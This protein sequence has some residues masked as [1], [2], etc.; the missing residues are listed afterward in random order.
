V[1]APGV[2]IYS[3]YLPTL[4]S[5]RSAS[6]TSTA[7]PHVSGLAGLLASK[8]YSNSEV[9]KRIESTAFDLGATGKDPEFGW[10]LI[11]AEAA[12][13]CVPDT[14][15]PEAKPPAQSFVAPSTLGTSYA[16]GQ[17]ATLP[18]KLDWSAIDRGGSGIARYELQQSTNSGASANVSLPSATA[19]NPPRHL[20]PN[21]A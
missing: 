11:D 3:T 9:R 7:A 5:Y 6:G 20:D 16:R 17:D 2:D 10:G 21:N 12:F 15:P 1:A 13:V 19:T 18:V 8:G 14:C 4:G